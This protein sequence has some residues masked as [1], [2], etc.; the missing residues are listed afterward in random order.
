MKVIIIGGGASGVICALKI[1][2]NN[3]NIAVAIFEQND[4]ILK[5]VLKTG[6][7]KCNILNTNICEEYYND[8]SLI[9][10]N[11]NI[12]VYE[13]L[14][15][16]GLVLKEMSLG[17]IYPYSE[18]AKTVVNVLIKDLDKYD[19]EVRVNCE[20]KD[21]KVL[22]KGFC[23]N[24]NDYCDFVVMASGSYSQEHTNGYELIKKLGLKV[25][26]LSPGLVP[27]EVHEKTNHLSGIR[28]KCQA[29]IHDKIIDGEIQFKDNGLS[30]IMA[31]D[32]SRYLKDKDVV[33]LDLMPEYSISDLSKLFVGE[34]SDD[35]EK[36]FPKMLAYDLFKRC[37]GN[38]ELIIHEIKNYKFNYLK[39]MSFN[40]SQITLGGVYLDE[41]TNSFESKKIK[42]LYIIGEILNC[43]GASGGYNLYF[44]WLSGLVS[45]NSISI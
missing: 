6:N 36:I 18:Q 37:E 31:L 16:L 2:K 43:D 44:A 5:K 9:A 15:S 22:Q 23:I 33:Y 7:G 25:S 38:K 34:V 27:F 11:D 32:V 24:N 41:L 12:N 13:E 40:E 28:F 30:G 10:N 26:S 20:V 14:S 21:I 8:F 39:K 17:R 35:L 29:H 42:N 19:V 4:R 3:P 1:K 45:A